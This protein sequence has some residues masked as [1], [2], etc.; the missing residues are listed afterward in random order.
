MRLRLRSEICTLS[1]VLIACSVYDESLLVDGDDTFE[2]GTPTSSSGSGGQGPSAGSL[3]SSSTSQGSNTTS[4]TSGTGTTGSTEAGGTGGTSDGS[5]AS[6]TS[7]GGENTS[8]NNG[9]GGGDTTTSASSGGGSASTSDG[10]TGSGGSNGS[11]GTSGTG[12]T[13]GAVA[14]DP[15]LI[16]DLDDADGRLDPNYTGY[17]YFAMDEEDPD[18]E[19]EITA[20]DD[21]DT[22]RGVETT[23]AR[24]GSTHAMHAAGSWGGWGAALGFS[25]NQPDTK[26]IDGSVFSGISFYAR[27]SA[28]TTARLEVVTDATYDKNNHLRAEL[29]L[30][31]EWEYHEVLWRDLEEPDWDPDAPWEPETMLKVQFHF[32]NSDFDFWIDDVRF[33]E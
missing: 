31:N 1:A 18:A 20:P 26:P 7:Q 12:G 17:W 30:T 2:D 13:G 10:T 28:A 3:T 16:D 6:S 14:A 33:V 22:P 24:E 19:G 29:S 5:Q 8:S 27:A 11:G 4:S 25:F 23:P 32:D 9:G 15:L 21:T